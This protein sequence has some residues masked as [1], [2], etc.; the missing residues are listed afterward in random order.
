MFSR[1]LLLSLLAST[2]IGCATL[3]PAVSVTRFGDVNP[4]ADRELALAAAKSEESAEDVRV[5]QGQLPEGLELLEQSTTIAVARGYEQSYQVL[6]TVEAD[7][8]PVG[9]SLGITNLFWAPDY[10][11]GWRKALCYPQVP[12]KILTMSLWVAVPLHYPCWATIPGED[13][14]ME[15]LIQHVRKGAKAMGANLVVLTATGGISV[16]SHGQVVGVHKNVSLRGFAI[17]AGPVQGRPESA[18]GQTNL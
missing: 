2:S 5:V 12:L 17:K 3:R 1:V 18:P 8:G 16:S 14:R 15:P 9:S 6:G 4:K 10:D 7:Y 13:E 11:E